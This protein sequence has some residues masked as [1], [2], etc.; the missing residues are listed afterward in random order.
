MNG[1][2]GILLAAGFSRRFGQ[3]DK[4]THV[5]ANGDAIAVSAAKHLIEAIP[6]SIAVVRHTSMALAD[7]LTSMGYQLVF[8]EDQEQVMADSF[9][10][11]IRFASQLKNPTRGFIMTLADMPY[12]QPETIR[13]VGEALCNCHSIVIPTYLAQRGHPVGFSASFRDE[14]EALT[15]DEG[16]RAVI[17]RHPQQVHLLPTHDAGILMD[18]D[19]PSDLLRQHQT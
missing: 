6:T 8:C 2:V 19:V 11:G 9:T 12:I 17:K 13:D 16:A 10:K 5:L 4:L 1:I 7:T 15:G 14:L 18:I 3:Q